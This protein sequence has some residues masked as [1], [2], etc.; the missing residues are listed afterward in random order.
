MGTPPH[1]PPR[2]LKSASLGDR[3]Q[4]GVAGSRLTPQRQGMPGSPASTSRRV[5]DP[6]LCLASPAREPGHATGRARHLLRERARQRSA[7]CMQHAHLLSKP[8]S[9]RSRP[10]CAPGLPCDDGQVVPLSGP[11]FLELSHRNFIKCPKATHTA[12][13]QP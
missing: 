2:R 7:V 3:S 5:W 13:T 9:P 8:R 11:P 1:D 6:V 12:P 4:L 10:V